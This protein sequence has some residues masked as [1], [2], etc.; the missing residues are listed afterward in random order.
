MAPSFIL[1]FLCK[2]HQPAKRLSCAVLKRFLLS[3][4]AVQFICNVKGSQN[5]N[6]I[7]VRSACSL[8]DLLHSRIHEC[9]QVPYT[10]RIRATF[11]RI[12]LAKD[13]DLN[14]LHDPPFMMHTLLNKA[15]CIPSAERVSEQSIYE[16]L[17]VEWSEVVDSLANSYKLNRK[18]K[19][20]RDSKDDST[21]RGSVEFRQ[22]DA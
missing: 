18:A 4:Y 5:G 9:S 22:H 8:L 7:P 13:L 6:S 12:H 3:T 14:G 2:R 15:S 20:S 16:F 19:L 1:D 11:Q 10:I 21:F 17:R